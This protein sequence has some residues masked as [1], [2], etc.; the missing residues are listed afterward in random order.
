MESVRVFSVLKLA[1]KYFFKLILTDSE[2]H[3]NVSAPT[4]GALGK[5]QKPVSRNRNAAVALRCRAL[6]ARRQ[7]AIYAV[8]CP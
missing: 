3:G 8:A 2:P 7:A 6:R 5:P 1:I 4:A